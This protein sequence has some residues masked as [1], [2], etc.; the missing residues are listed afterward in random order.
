MQRPPRSAAA[1]DL[2][3]TP[4]SLEAA[5]NGLPAS[6]RDGFKKYRPTAP[7]TFL[8]EDDD[9]A[10][11]RDT[12]NRALRKY[13]DQ[14]LC[15]TADSAQTLASF[16]GPKAAL[17]GRRVTFA[18]GTTADEQDR[19]LAGAEIELRMIRNAS[20]DLLDSS[21]DIGD[22]W[23]LAAVDGRTDVVSGTRFVGEPFANGC[24][25]PSTAFR[26]KQSG[27]GCWVWEPNGFDLG[28]N[29]WQFQSV[30]WLC[31]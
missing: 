3:D 15:G 2:I 24:W 27:I 7:V 17:Q 10:M 13:F 9:G 6:L 28:L 29:V 23:V 8:K 14:R 12:W 26:A 25:G 1:P 21:L 30:S 18:P 11:S 5:L 16:W 19:V 31:K 22:N 20:T 4:I